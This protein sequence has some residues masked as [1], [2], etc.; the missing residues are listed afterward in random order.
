ME[1]RPIYNNL[2]IKMSQCW[3]DMTAP[4]SLK[5]QRVR[6]MLILNMWEVI[7]IGKTDEAA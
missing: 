4:R 2:V 6:G 7:K 5:C 3:S 1:L